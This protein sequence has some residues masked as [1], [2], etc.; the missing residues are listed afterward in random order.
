MHA[1]CVLSLL[2]SF[3]L[4]T[5]CQGQ[6]N[7][8][9]RQRT[10]L[11]SS[12]LP[13]STTLEEDQPALPV[14][15][16][17]D[18]ETHLMQVLRRIFQD[19]RGNLWFVGDDVFCHDGHTLHDLTDQEVFRKSVVRQ[20]TEDQEGNIWFGT[21]R[22]IVRYTPSA[23]GKADSGT[24]SQYT[25]ED[26]LVHDDV[27]SLAIDKKGVVWIGTL[28]GVSR[29][30]GETFT[31]FELPEA[32]V[33]KS[34]GVSSARMVHSIME[35][36]HG[37]IW[38]ATNGGAYNFDGRSLSNL[39]EQEGLC[40]NS[41]NDMLEDRNGNIWFATHHNGVCRWDGTS[42]THFSAKDGI[43]GTEAWSLYEDRSGHIWFPIEN[44]GVYRYDGT[45]FTNFYRKEGLP[46]NAV[47][48][49]LEDTN[50]RLWFGGFGGLYCYDGKSFIQV[51]Q[52]GP[53]PE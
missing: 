37:N 1:P 49:I 3:F 48:S 47:H 13:Q 39:S 20:I 21:M 11:E 4:I 10:P 53:W 18:P 35:D 38:F 26:G 22:G 41:V 8:K 27:W 40:H 44:D 51:T 30:N 52:D 7:P 32:P 34:R 6:E 46:L 23:D 31:S 33:D 50:G 19:S 15:P 43:K 12:T 17:V 36:S 28:E 25:V 14:L 45:S 2:L 16:T 24:F 9:F 42:F 29:F 5:S